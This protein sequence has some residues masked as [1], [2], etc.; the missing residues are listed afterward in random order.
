MLN[1][2]LLA[3][4]NAPK[5]PSLP[6][7]G[8]GGWLNNS[9]DSYVTEE[10]R[11]FADAGIR[12]FQ[13][14]QKSWTDRTRFYATQLL[15]DLAYR[16]GSHIIIN[17]RADIAAMTGAAGVH[18]PEAGLAVPDARQI[19][20]AGLIGVSCHSLTAALSAETDGADY[21][22]FGPVYD[23]ESKRA[24]GQPKGIEA[25]R[26]VCEQITL[27]VFAVGGITPKRAEECRA[28]G[29]HGVSVIG[30]LQTRDLNSIVKEFYNS[31]GGL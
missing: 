17:E 22:L 29:A 23:T 10:F 19:F 3:I 11:R 4:S 20:P 15:V 14:R 26:E 12:A 28:A 8:V 9:T 7:E 5:A 24:F 18:L 25:L 13:L 16:Y 2:R 27:P 1:F 31:L 21:I 30:A 6:K